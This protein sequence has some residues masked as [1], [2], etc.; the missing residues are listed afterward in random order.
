MA[1]VDIMHC[2]C[3]LHLPV[4]LKRSCMRMQRGLCVHELANIDMHGK[5]FTLE[6]GVNVLEILR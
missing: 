6:V 2:N 4:L 1:Y 5:F 3:R